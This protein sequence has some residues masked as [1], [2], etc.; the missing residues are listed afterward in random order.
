MSVNLEG[1]TPPQILGTDALGAVLLPED[2]LKGVTEVEEALKNKD[3]HRAAII[4]EELSGR[5]DQNQ[6][7]AQKKTLEKKLCNLILQFSKLANAHEVQDLTKR[8]YHFQVNMQFAENRTLF[9]LK[10]SYFEV[11]LETAKL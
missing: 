10:G 8:L 7:V 2:L 1:S 11:N 6:P 4:L 9:T 5:F 3:L